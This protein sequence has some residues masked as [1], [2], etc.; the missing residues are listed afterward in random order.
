MVDVVALAAVVVGR[1]LVPRLTD[2]AEQMLSEVTSR[3][4][5]AAADAVADVS[6]KVWDRIRGLFAKDAGGAA[7]F[8]EFEQ[9]PEQ[10]RPAV[11]AMLAK[12]L[13]ENPDV[14][15]ELEALLREP[16]PGGGDVVQLTGEVVG[17]L[18]A[19]GATNYGVMGGVVQ[20]A[21]TPRK[22]AGEGASDDG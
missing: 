9:A 2:G 1:F 5:K 22:P 6:T 18:S 13:E 19:P 14:A 20:G 11:E 16:V 15:R 17:Y 8:E 10:M 21:Q 7:V 3:A 4:G 12:R